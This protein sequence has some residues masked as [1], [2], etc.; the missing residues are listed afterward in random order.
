MPGVVLAVAICALA[1]LPGL[2]P[3]NR[4]KSYQKCAGPP[5]VVQFPAKFGALLKHVFTR[6]IV[7]HGRVRGKSARPRHH[8][9]FSGMQ[10]A[11]RRVH[12]ERPPRLTGLLPGREPKRTAEKLADGIDRHGGGQSRWRLIETG[13]R[14]LGRQRCPWKAEDRGATIP[15]EGIRLGGPIQIPERSGEPVE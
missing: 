10:V 13:V 12:T 4:S 1:I 8:V 14:N 9:A 2:T 7:K 3:V 5:L 11:T 6:R 15:P